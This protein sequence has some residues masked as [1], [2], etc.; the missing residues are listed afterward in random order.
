VNRIGSSEP[1]DPA[2]V[3]PQRDLVESA[4]QYRLRIEAATAA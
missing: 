4:T 2:F 3:P 1:D